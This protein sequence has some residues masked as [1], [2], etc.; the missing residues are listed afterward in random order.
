MAKKIKAYVDTGAFIAFLDR[1][2]TYHSL[3]LRLF[4]DPPPL[5]TTPLVIAEGHG[6]FLK[7]F[8]ATRALQFLN[9]V[10]EL[11]P[12]EIIDVGGKALKE[13]GEIL[14]KFSD[15]DVTLADACGLWLM[16]KLKILSCWSTDRHLALMRVPLVIH[17]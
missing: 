4:A 1:S 12:L 17:E 10:E 7:R 9:F 16:K 14:R 5:V 11:T 3:F 8:D 2:D 6:W 13:S 15:Q